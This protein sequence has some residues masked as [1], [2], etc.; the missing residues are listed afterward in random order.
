MEILQGLEG[1][2]VP[3]MT[4]PQ[5]KA[6]VREN[7]GNAINACVAEIDKQQRPEIHIA[8]LQGKI[9]AYEKALAHQK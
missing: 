7:L 5:E 3:L 9:E 4:D 6:A 2:L 8:Y 1:E